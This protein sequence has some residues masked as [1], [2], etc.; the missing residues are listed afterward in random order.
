[1]AV[2]A[3]ERSIRSYLIIPALGLVAVLQ[4]ALLPHARLWGVFPN[5]MLV[6]VVSWSLLRGADQGM[7]WAFVGGLLLDL[8]SG[9][10]TGAGTL[11]LMAVAFLAGIGEVNVFRTHLILPLATVLLA[12]LLYGALMLLVLQLTGRPVDWA[13]SLVTT[14]VP[15]AIVNTLLTPLVYG[16]VYWLHRLLGRDV[17]DW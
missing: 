10:P 1:M 3:R 2:P 12:S 14:V 7:V 8:L 9:G 5:L 17:I 16:I 4:S 6:V 15:S 13:G 11:S